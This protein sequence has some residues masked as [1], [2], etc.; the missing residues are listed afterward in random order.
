MTTDIDDAAQIQAVNTYFRK[1]DTNDPTILDIFTDDVQIFFPKMGL[2][3][4]KAALVKFSEI[5]MNHLESIEHDIEA[6]NYIISGNVVVV[7]GTERGL[8][9][10]GIRWPD[11]VVSQGRFCNVFEFDGRLIRRV[12]VYV[13]PDFT[14]ADRDRIQIFQ[15]KQTSSDMA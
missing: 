12:H 5:L 9:R 11:S 15:S 13:D 14:S 3:H 1:V 2:A 7:E 10:Q 6:F 8:T 4:G